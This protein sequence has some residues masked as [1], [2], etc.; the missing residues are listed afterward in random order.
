MHPSDSNVFRCPSTTVRTRP[1]KGTPPRSLNQAT[2]APLKL[3]P[4]GRTKS[5]PGSLMKSG[6]RESGPAIVLRTKARS[7]TERPRHPEVLKVDHANAAFGFGTRPIDGRK[8]TT[9]QK[10]AGLRS[11]PPVSEPLATGVSPHASATAA[12]SEDPPHVLVKSYGLRVAPKTLL[13][14]CDPAPNSGVL[15]LPMV[16]APARRILSTTISSSVGM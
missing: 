8:P 3:R 13:N 9:L 12:P 14:V 4:S 6:A 16:I 11:E 5:S 1:S 7:A 15:V 10:A 2:R